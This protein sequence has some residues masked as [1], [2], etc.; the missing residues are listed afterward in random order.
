MHRKT[1]RRAALK[2]LGATPL[3]L[4]GGAALV[5]RALAEGARVQAPTAAVRARVGTGPVE[6]GAGSWQPVSAT[7]ARAAM[8]DPAP[9]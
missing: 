2:I 7:N 8:A 1:G 3:G 6:P 5:D 9:R 4:A